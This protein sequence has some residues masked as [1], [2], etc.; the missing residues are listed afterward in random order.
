[1]KKNNLPLFEVAALIIGEALV[2][3]AVIII[4]ILLKKFSY[5][6]VFGTLLG[7]AVTL[8]NF[9]ILSATANRAIDRAMQNR[10]EG[11]LDEDEAAEF[12]A[13]NQNQLQNAMRVSYLIRTA[14]MVA[15]LVLAFLLKDVFHVIATVIPLIAFQPII[16]I[17]TILKRRVGK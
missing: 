4:F 12:A 9:A 10:P 2:S 11:E 5:Q 7:T 1:M 13:K 8:I 17:S 6:V 15:T 16:A 14:T 3:L